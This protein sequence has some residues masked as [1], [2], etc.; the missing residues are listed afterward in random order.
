MPDNKL[1]WAWSLIIIV[2]L[3]WASIY[4][5]YRL[6][7]IVEPELGLIIMEIIIDL[8]FGLD[9]IINFFTAFYDNQ[10]NLITKKTEIAK[11]YLKT[12]FLIDLISM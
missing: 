9:I 1:G 6:A 3:L 11:N 12:W 4:L 10:N 5:P 7:F 2:L 8:L